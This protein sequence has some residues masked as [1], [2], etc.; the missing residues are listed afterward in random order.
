MVQIHEGLHPRLR[1]VREAESLAYPEIQVYTLRLFV[2][3]VKRNAQKIPV[4]GHFK[5]TFCL[6]SGMIFE[7]I[8]LYPTE[9]G[10]PDMQILATLI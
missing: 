2:Q 7:I 5:L 8:S 4:A 1:Q 9:I 6:V 3:K 10:N